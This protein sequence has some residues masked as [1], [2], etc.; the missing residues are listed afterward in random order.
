MMADTAE[1]SC[2]CLPPSPADRVQSR[3]RA[4]QRQGVKDNVRGL[5]PDEVARVQLFHL[6]KELIDGPVERSPI[7]REC[8]DDQ[9]DSTGVG[10]F[11]EAAII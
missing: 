9:V 11:A 3:E 2:L 8:T 10:P 4:C 1:V 6:V 5:L 7:N